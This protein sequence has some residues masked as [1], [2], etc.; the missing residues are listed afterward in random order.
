MFMKCEGANSSSCSQVIFVYLHP[1]R[2]SSLFYSWKSPKNHQNPLFWWFRSFK[3]IVDTS[4]KHI[5]S[6]CY[7]KRHICA[8]LQLFSRWTNQ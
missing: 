4:K 8:C 3:V 1:F 5:T 2:R 6:A 7:D